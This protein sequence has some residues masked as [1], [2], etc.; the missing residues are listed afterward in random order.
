MESEGKPGASLL[1]DWRQGDLVDA[2]AFTFIGPDGPQTEPVDTLVVIS[3]SCDLVRPELD[4][5]YLQVAPLV[6]LSGERLAMAA[7]GATPRFVPLL[8]AGPDAFADLDRVMTVH[9]RSASAWHRHPASLT[10]SASLAIRNALARY[11]SRPAFP[12]DFIEAI[13][14]LRKRLVARTGKLSPE[15]SAATALLEIRVRADWDSRPVRPLL[16][17]IVPP[18][19]ELGVDGKTILD[20]AFWEHQ[21]DQWQGLCM[22]VG[23]VDGVDCVAANYAELDALTYIE[24]D[25]LDLDYLSR[26]SAVSAEVG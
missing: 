6:R 24:S 1:A 25:P 19:D 18:G 11:Y 10:S 3:Q 17:F 14:N 22:A 12:D 7:K 20:L 26:P 13:G 15:G 16:F 23:I 9:K 4:R 5:P 8:H 2:L 21:V